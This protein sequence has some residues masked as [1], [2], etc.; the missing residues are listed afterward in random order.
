MQRKE[1]LHLTLLRAA[2]WMAAAAIFAFPLCGSLGMVSAAAGAG[3]AVYVSRVG[4]IARL[5]WPWIVAAAIAIVAASFWSES[6][7]GSW[8]VFA[9]LIG[10]GRALATIEAV[11]FGGM[12]FGGVLALRTLSRQWPLLV[13]LEAATIVAGVAFSFR[14][15]RQFPFS[16]PQVLSDWAFLNGYDPRHIIM[17]I[18]LAT[19]VGL[20]L[21][22]LPRQGLRRTLIAAAILLLFSWLLFPWLI[23]PAVT[24]LADIA[25]PVN[26]QPDAAQ[27]A[28]APA[29]PG[30]AKPFF[31]HKAP[32]RPAPPPPPIPVTP[33][34]S[35]SIGDAEVVEGHAGTTALT[36]Q[37]TLSAPTNKPV[38]VN[39]RAASGSAN[40]NSDYEPLN[41]QLTIPA[42][43][44]E[45]T[46]SVNV[47]GDTTVE[48]NETVFVAMSSPANATIDR[49]QG[50]GVILNDDKEPV[51]PLLSVSDVNVKE[52]D[53]GITAAEVVVSLSTA[54]PDEVTVSFSAA[55]GT[56][57]DRDCEVPALTLK[58]PP[59][60]TQV[61]VPIRIKGDVQVE[62]DETF[63]VQL[64]DATGAVIERGR[65]TGMIVNDDVLPPPP[66]LTIN[67]ATEHEGNLGTRSMAFELSLSE[68]WEKDLDVEFATVGDTAT[69]GEDFTPQQ[70]TVTIPRQHTRVLVPIAIHGDNTPEA[71]EQFQVQLTKPQG[72][73]LARPAG[74]GT[75]LNDDFPPEISIADAEIKEGDNGTT[76]LEFQVELSEPYH[77][78][79]AVEFTASGQT[80]RP[81]SD[82]R[83]TSGRVSFAA[84]QT[85][86]TVTLRVNGDPDV[87]SD[88]TLFVRL[89]NPVGAIL[90]RA[91]AVGT[92]L[93]DD[94]YPRI[95]I[96]DNSMTE[97]DSGLSPLTFT[98]TLSKPWHK[99]IPV[100]YETVV[101]GGVRRTAFYQTASQEQRKKVQRPTRRPG[102]QDRERIRRE[103]L[104]R[105]MQERRGESP[106][107]DEPPPAADD[108][109][110]RLLAATPKR[111][112]LPA[113]GVLIFFPRETSKTI[114]VQIVGDETAELDEMFLVQLSQPVEATLERDEATGTIVNDDPLPKVSV[115]DAKGKEGDAG[116]SAIVFVIKLSKPAATPVE[117]GYETE[118]GTAKA[119][120]DFIPTRGSIT[121][122]VGATQAQVP[123]RIPGDAERE[124]PES[125][126]MKFDPPGNAEME[127]NE[128]TG[129]I[130]DED[131]ENDEDDEDDDEDPEITIGDV[132]LEE[133][134]A[135]V[136]AFV[137]PVTLSK[138]T[139]KE[140]EVTYKTVAGSAEETEDY[141]PAEGTLK[142]PP[143]TTEGNITVNVV[144]DET[145]ED[146]EAFEVSLSEPKNATL[147]DETGTG[148]ILNDDKPTLSIDDVEIDEGDE[149][150]S[151]AKFTVTLSEA[152]KHDVS[153]RYVTVEGTAEPDADFEPVDDRLTIPT[154][155]TT[156]SITVKVVAD[157]EAEPQENFQVALSEPEGAG[158]D[159]DTGLATIDND[160][161]PTL[162]IEDF[163]A[164][165]GNSETTQFVFRV[166]LSSATSKDVKVKYT[167]TAGTA[168][169]DDDFQVAEETL[170]I[171]AGETE[172]S[173]TIEVVADEVIEKDEEFEVRLSEPENVIVDD[174]TATGTILND[175]KPKLSIDDVEVEEGDEPTKEAAFTATLSEAIEEDVT[176]HYKTVPDTALADDDYQPL[177]DELTI[178]AGETIAKIVVSVIGDEVAELEEQ[179]KVVLS[180]PVKAEL[181]KET[182]L[183]TIVND[184]DPSV[185]IADF[186]AEEG[187]GEPTPF[188]FKVTLSSATSKDVEVDY[189]CAPGTAVAGED[190]EFVEETLSIPSGTTEG[191]ITVEIIA[192]DRIE[193][194]EAFE[195]QL[196]NPQNATIE[197]GTAEASILNDDKPDLS[198]VDR[199]ITE[200]P[201]TIEGLLNLDVK[202]S[203][204]IE[205]DVSFKYSTFDVTAKAGSDYQEFK[206]QVGLIPAGETSFTIKLQPINDDEVEPEETFEVRLSDP[207]KAN[208]ERGTSVVTIASEDIPDATIEGAQV[209]EGNS[210]TTSITFKVTLSDPAG[211]E[212][213]LNYFV[214]SRTALVR[215]DFN[216]VEGTLIIPVG[217]SESSITV[218]VI[219]D[220][221]VEEDE[222]FDVFL[223]KPVLVKIEQNTASG[224]IINDDFFPDVTIDDVEVTE[225]HAGTTA[226]RF[227]VKLS[228]ASRNEIQVD[229]ETVAGT[230]AADED[231]R[232]LTGTLKVPI[233]QTE[234]GLSVEVV[235][236]NFV[237]EDETFE[238]RLSNIVGGALVRDR[239]TGT[240]RNDDREPPPPAASIGHAEVDEGHEGKTALEFLARLSRPAPDDVTVHY[241]TGGGTA[242]PDEDYDRAE[243]DVTIP[244][245][246]QEATIT[247]QVRGDAEPE[248]DET[249]ELH[250]SA[251][252]GATLA[253]YKAIG[254]IANDDG[255]PPEDSAA[256]E[257]FNWGANFQGPSEPVLLLTI[258]D[259]YA[260]VE[261]GFY[262]RTFAY[263]RLASARLRRDEG[264]D[265]DIAWSLPQHGFQLPSKAP[266]PVVRDFS[267]QAYLIAEQPTLPTIVEAT[268]IS[269]RTN[270]VPEEFLGAYDITSRVLSSGFRDGKTVEAYADLAQRPVGD[271]NWDE[272]TRQHYLA[273][274]DDGRYR[275][276][277][278]DIARTLNS[279]QRESPFARMAA[280]KEWMS[281]NL[282]FDYNPA[283]QAADDPTASFLFGDRR[284]YC[285]HLAH[286]MTYLLRAQGIP[287][288]LAAGYRVGSERR[289]QRRGFLVYTGDAHAWAEM[290]VEG[291]GWVV[292]EAA[293]SGR[294][295]PPDP[296]PDPKEVDYYLS[297]LG[298]VPPEVFASSPGGWRRTAAVGG[299]ASLSLGL[300]L[301]Y[302]IKFM[303]LLLPFV[304]ETAALYRIGYRSVLDR[305]AQVGIR[306]HYAETWDEFAGRV[307]DFAPDFVPLTEMHLQKAFS[308][309][310]IDKTQWKE[311]QKQVVRQIRSHVPWTKRWLGWMNPLS[312]LGVG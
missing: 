217:Q 108:P 34:P 198:I 184:D 255:A 35:L 120:V 110:T 188:E 6:L 259:D 123:I 233:G 240:I 64:A 83:Q 237:E 265:D 36:Y 300:I 70:G 152:V 37:V 185:T 94:E 281:E 99:P 253:S 181:D 115:D 38:T 282:T 189:T 254:T 62:E 14:A 130:D 145:V 47:T 192:D 65:G 148:S 274:P 98:V 63:V 161:D 124:Q 128:A 230:A 232:T 227:V 55:E 134:S 310:D 105:R 248:Q 301:L 114:S 111:D 74:L 241:A 251:P 306:R 5:R 186:E 215:D 20:G 175:D 203:E 234:A 245:G 67:D 151:E 173:I 275:S 268:A 88:E 129:T 4:L 95:S 236:D 276:L 296:E 210:G 113:E 17:T 54:V 29:P 135:G 174:D 278:D 82:F 279:Q 41:G 142:I 10:P 125:F 28:A 121:I 166:S 263:S 209:E 13:I 229:Y 48:E 205:E 139:S 213:T 153:F 285:I 77:A 177:D 211:M 106:E 172:T 160:D 246:E 141:E 96:A 140:V 272:E 21:L 176:F 155:Q 138:P 133:G 52:G 243:G 68:P 260:P 59:G 12:L 221:Q 312:W 159:K 168:V 187:T 204:A 89:H 72:I 261:N 182:G 156:A 212:A 222:T 207:V 179:Y 91:Q 79:V 307:G 84:G 119:G 66:T 80:A 76:R 157:K 97:G 290:Y 247:V 200:E 284:G 214:D 297:L 1:G 302:A 22:M 171:P 202:L 85:Q 57:D 271:P 252:Q 216:Y 158:L 231:F 295:P 195:I 71:D 264:R 223:T 225:G 30:E 269:S 242:Y 46:V 3:L 73:E 137:F 194:D 31:N 127:N 303:R 201:P 58:F 49:D 154:G 53:S 86:K 51:I 2:V 109:L 164:E 299:T 304:M 104:E 224:T 45:A 25:R 9:R 165:E 8:T 208:I 24:A 107:P 283:H 102:A 197:D 100:R 257:E 90:G 136:T 50:R 32:A 309:A 18:G 11:T 235:G 61:S 163:E 126:K 92:I 87:E 162:S 150:T 238:V 43:Q 183:G 169:E 101:Y 122:P 287:A 103:M 218:E 93:N 23:G 180:D 69:E 60:E 42:G 288:R 16:Q 19:L 178:S 228:E 289:G 206:E 199:Y 78:P 270:P 144:A 286:A 305:L 147:K 249:F 292:V 262:V 273:I 131:E 267:Y 167:A 112:Y 118:E 308:D 116:E 26:N 44:T 39:V 15:H 170:T 191:I 7:I 117:I 190:F 193:K 250:L 311:L 298:D 294:I 239:A 56:A 143:G 81:G 226:A 27:V 256:E 277:A 146:D 75:I 33:L 220:T 266:V 40:E 291:V 244:A 258:D 196:S 219:G 280:T 149:S 132:E 293:T